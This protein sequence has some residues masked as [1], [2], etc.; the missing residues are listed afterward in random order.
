MPSNPAFDYMQFCNLLKNLESTL[1]DAIWKLGHDA[2]KEIERLQSELEG[3]KRTVI[4]QAGLL[5]RH[6]REN[7]KIMTM[8]ARLR[9]EGSIVSPTKP[10][11]AT[12]YEIKGV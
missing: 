11:D 5:D 12:Q 4:I 2:K 6:C 3:Y 7:A 10:H 8:M 9:A 1:G